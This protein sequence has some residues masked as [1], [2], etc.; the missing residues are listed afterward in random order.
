MSR[1]SFLHPTRLSNYYETEK[2]RYVY[3]GGQ[4]FL[5][6]YLYKFSERETNEEFN[7]RKLLTPIPSFAKTAI[8]EVRN[9]IFQRL[10]D[11]TRTGGSKTYRASVI[12][13]AR[14][15]D[16]HKRSMTAYLGEKVIHELL[17]MGTVGIW[18]DAPRETP[19]SVAAAAVSDF[20]PYLYHYRLEDILNWDYD[21]ETGELTR[22]I[23]RD[24]DVGFDTEL[25]FPSGTS[26]KYR[27]AWIDEDDG[28]V[29]I[30]ISAHTNFADSENGK[31]AEIIKLNLKKIPFVIGDL[32]TSLM[33]EIA[34]H[35]IALLNL[36]SSNVSYSV[37]G[38]FSFYTEQRNKNVGSHLIGG[39]VGADGSQLGNGENTKD[40]IDVGAFKGRAY[41]E[42]MDRPGFIHPSS[43]PLKASMEMCERL[44]DEIRQLVSLAITNLGTRTS[45]ESK[46]ADQQGLEA[47]LSFIGLVL[48]T[49][50]REIAE[51]WHAYE[52]DSNVP[53]IKYPNRW[54]LRTSE[55]R[56][57]E[58]TKVYEAACKIPGETA[59]KVASKLF[60]NALVGNHVSTTVLDQIHAEI[61]NSAYTT[62]DPL[63][64]QMGHELGII[65]GATASGALG[66]KQTEAKKAQ[67]EYVEKQRRVA[68]AQAGA[69][70]GDQA[71]AQ[72]E[73]TAGSDVPLDDND[74][75]A[76]REQKRQQ[77]QEATG[78]TTNPQRGRQRRIT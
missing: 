42:G 2:Y 59:K 72:A 16:R 32:G 15:V 68:E 58:A 56:I 37:G 7:R 44:K 48:E 35:Q 43:E 53:T 50:E 46:A 21:S 62:S 29:R 5:H 77:R 41:Q 24:Q 60:I 45:G 66:F 23:L 38:L 78:D 17:V 63:I 12:G 57:D 3:E 36:S 70:A 11:V 28:Y 26:T 19:Q 34:N 4:R 64:I 14:G 20:S 22:I 51:H 18:V 74:A 31:E 76:Q 75:A 6:K 13:E 10:V 1:F 54:N 61:D 52:E 8:N 9:S 65:S 67:D 39:Q 69:Q 25:G 73:P 40:H 71:G 47:G 33:S 27:K 30:Q 49:M 55:Q